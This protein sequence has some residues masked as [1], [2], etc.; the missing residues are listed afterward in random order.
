MDRRGINVGDV[1]VVPEGHHLSGER[2]MVHEIREW[3]IVSRSFDRNI[4][5]PWSLLA[6]QRECETT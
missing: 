2:I 1:L 4:R 6:S 3:G 5:L